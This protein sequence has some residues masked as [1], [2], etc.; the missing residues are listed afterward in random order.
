MIKNNLGRKGF[1]SAHSSSVHHG[2]QSGQGL[3]TGTWKQELGQRPSIN[4]A[5]QLAPPDLLR[6]L[7]HTPQNHLCPGAPP[8]LG[9]VLPQQLSVKKMPPHLPC[10]QDNL[11]VSQPR[12]LLPR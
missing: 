6:L 9:Q 11:M 7:S 3:K 8:T 5:D 4:T 2:V 12:F 1:I 10:L